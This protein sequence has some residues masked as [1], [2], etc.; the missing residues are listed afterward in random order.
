M[1]RWQLVVFVVW[2]GF[3]AWGLSTGRLRAGTD[4]TTLD[5]GR[6]EAP[7]PIASAPGRTPFQPVTPDVHAAPQ[8]EPALL[9]GAP[10]AGAPGA[11]GAEPSKEDPALVR[12]AAATGALE[13][14]GPTAEAPTTPPADTGGA[15]GSLQPAPL[16]VTAQPAASTDA[17]VDALAVLGV[18]DDGTALEVFPI[19]VVNRRPGA[20]DDDDHT[21]IWQDDSGL[22]AVQRSKK[23]LRE[24]A[25]PPRT[26][27]PQRAEQDLITRARKAL[28]EG[29]YEDAR[30]A[31]SHARGWAPDSPEPWLL[32][33][34]IAR[35]QS[36][37]AEAQYCYEQAKRRGGRIGGYETRLG[38]E[39]KSI[40]TL[41]RSETAHATIAAPFELHEPTRIALHEQVEQA[42]AHV[43]QQLG[44]EPAGKVTVVL[45]RD[46]EFSQREGAVLWAAGD[47]DGR[48][49]LTASAAGSARGHSTLIHELTHH[50]VS[51]HG[52]GAVPA[53]FNEGV[54]QQVTQLAVGDAPIHCGGGHGFPLTTL[55]EGFGRM[56]SC[57]EAHAAY[58]TAFH[59]V[60]R[61]V[62]RTPLSTAFPRMGG[63]SFARA[64]E[65]GFGEPLET[66]IKRFDAEGP[67]AD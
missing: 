33:A 14:P 38:R 13:P 16:A 54:A 11:T 19:P 41:S 46:E 35:K 39:A 45:Y 4:E 1:R 26:T 9:T 15:T 50:F 53:W 59:A 20:R 49:R 37:V 67:Q 34:E 57:R 43:R 18:A 21:V 25:R 58:V 51:A 22:I 27:P 55:V 44:F 36:D 30:F 6:V 7:Q 47:Y 66:F 56:E 17:G 3:V 48:V 8:P 64:F 42:W 2:A 61:L 5:A 10:S 24:L 28:A 60:Q 12:D 31:A 65:A 29:R 23:T 63:P 52:L 62:E 32:L 40:G